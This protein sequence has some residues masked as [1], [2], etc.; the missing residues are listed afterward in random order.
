MNK[1]SC[2]I[3]DDQQHCLD[4]LSRQLSSHAH[5]LDLVGTAYG[6]DDGLELISSRK[7]DL[8]F[9][10]VEL[11]DKTG[12]DILNNLPKPHP[13][14]VFV[15]AMSHYSLRA[16]RVSAADYLLKPV[17][18]QELHE[19]IIR[20]SQEHQR[21]ASR[22][23]TELMTTIP[24]SKDFKPDRIAIRQI[25]SLKLIYYADL[26]YVEADSNYSKFYTTTKDRITTSM[27]LKEV[28]ETLQSEVFLRC[29]KSYL[30]NRDFVDEVSGGEKAFLT[31]RNGTQIPIARRRAKE[32]TRLLSQR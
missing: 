30:V 22:R 23:A 27:T 8:I 2:V 29:H 6:Y 20:V 5:R 10:D 9:L 11:G 3:I 1:L 13:V 25:D 4:D 28:E 14:I 16:I 7:P 12:F 15:S 26:M 21:S 17:S 31:M 24:I 18:D 19:V 32:V